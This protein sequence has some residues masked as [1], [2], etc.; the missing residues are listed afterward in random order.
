MANPC[1]RLCCPMKIDGRQ[2]PSCLFLHLVAGSFISFLRGRFSGRDSHPG[3]ATALFAECV[4][5]T[6][7]RD[8][9]PSESPTSLERGVVF[10]R[11]RPHGGFFGLVVQVSHSPVEEFRGQQ[12]IAVRGKPWKFWFRFITGRA[13]GTR[14]V[15]PG[16]LR[17]VR[18]IT[19]DWVVVAGAVC[20]L[21]MEG[22]SST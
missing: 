1:S 7:A 14:S 8:H 10:W 6:R 3:V 11:C 20:E 2:I 16:H 9:G 21:L 22:L 18:A 13:S 5:K 12:A 15:D 19:T 4:V 17:L